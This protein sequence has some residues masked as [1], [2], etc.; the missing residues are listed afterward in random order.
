LLTPPEAPDVIFEAHPESEAA[1][2][3]RTR[4]YAIYEFALQREWEARN[5][6]ASKRPLAAQVLRQVRKLGGV[7]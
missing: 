4:G 7:K 5:L 3:L 6:F 2:W 1:E